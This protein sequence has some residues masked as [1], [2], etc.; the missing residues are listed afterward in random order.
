MN[1][2]EGKLKFR[3]KLEH[4]DPQNVN[5]KVPESSVKDLFYRSG[6]VKT[7]LH[8][9]KIHQHLPWTP[10]KVSVEA[11]SLETAPAHS[12]QCKYLYTNF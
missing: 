8:L 4:A 11:V 6:D 3:L 7:I 9:Q 1:K 10:L 12:A 5:V 2:S